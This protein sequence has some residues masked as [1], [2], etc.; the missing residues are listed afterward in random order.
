MFKS[1]DLQFAGGR[2]K[3]EQ[4]SRQLLDILSELLEFLAL[5]QLFAMFNGSIQKSAWHNESDKGVHATEFLLLYMLRQ[6]SLLPQECRAAGPN[7][8]CQR[9]MFN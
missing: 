3:N 9:F 1:S 7:V 4:I 6:N 2:F 8:L 5:F